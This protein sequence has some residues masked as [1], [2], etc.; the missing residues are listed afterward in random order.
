MSNKA[1]GRIIVISAASGSGK[2]TLCKRLLKES[3]GLV[4]S[5]SFTTRPLRRGEKSNRD[6]IFVTKKEFLAARKN[7]RFLEWANVFGNYYGTPVDFVNKKTAIGKSVLLVIDVKGAFK[8]KKAV[9]EAVLIFI[10]PPSMAELERRLRQRKS[11]G[12]KQIAFRLKIAKKEIAASGKYDYAVVNDEI[13]K[14]VK[15]L[16]DIINLS[17][18]KCRGEQR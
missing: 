11:D 18:G 2:T 16:K 10:L 1:K 13:E 5:K 4:V 15:K 8:V 7:N 3:K 17:T 14:A 6:Y 9:P 12:V